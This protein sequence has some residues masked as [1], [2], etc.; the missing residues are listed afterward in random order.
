MRVYEKATLEAFCKTEEVL[1]GMDSV[2]MKRA[3]KPYDRGKTAE[4]QAEELIAII[5]KKKKLISFY[6]DVK[7]ALKSLKPEHEKILADRYGFGDDGV[8]FEKDRNYFK[9]LLLATEKFSI[10]MQNLGYTQDKYEELAAEFYFFDEILNDKRE[11]EKNARN[12]GK[13]RYS[14]SSNSLLETTSSLTFVGDGR[15]KR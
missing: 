5:E 7:K 4:R 1:E 9:K 8:T 14:S 3:F 13:L 6:L 10:A 15:N 11:S 12:I 2:F